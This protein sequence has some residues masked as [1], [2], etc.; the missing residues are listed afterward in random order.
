VTTPIVA[1]RPADKHD[2][3]EAAAICD[4]RQRRIVL[5]G[6]GIQC[7]RPIQSLTRCH[8]VARPAKFQFAL[9]CNPITS[10]GFSEFSGLV[11]SR[12]LSGR[13]HYASIDLS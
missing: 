10:R 2:I 3:Q 6:V 4:V 13:R 8:H 11:Q 12:S 9:N 7:L 5:L 1:K